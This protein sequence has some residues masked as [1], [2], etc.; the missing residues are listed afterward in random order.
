M[1]TLLLAWHQIDGGMFAAAIHFE[2]EIEPVAFVERCHP[3]ALDR[4][5]M[6]ER[7]GLSVIALDEAEAFHRVEELDRAAGLFAGQLTLRRATTATEA[8]FAW[9]CIAVTRGRTIGDGE[10]FAVDLEI[11][12]RHLA[13]AIDEREAERLA[14]GKSR[15][16]GLFDRRNVHENIFAAIIT[17][18]KAETFLPVEEFDDAGAFADYL[19][20]HAATGTTAA[21]AGKAAATAATAAETTTAAAESVATA[22][23]E[24]ITAAAAKTITATGKATAVT[25]AA[26]AAAFVTETVAFIASASAAI[27][28]ASLIE[29]HAVPVLSSKSPACSFKKLH[30]P[31]AG[32]ELPGAPS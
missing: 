8:A 15:Q 7:I 27:A 24:A 1:K 28:A 2:F 4:R 19:C 5:D 26:A 12:C 20:G 32:M 31:D 13:A 21:T 16:T 25:T 22:T 14:L 9:C 6:D 17:D 3:G 23:A 10:R 30:A 29:T 11:G 18:D